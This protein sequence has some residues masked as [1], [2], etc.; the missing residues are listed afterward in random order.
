MEAKHAAELAALEAEQRRYQ[1]REREIEEQLKKMEQ[2]YEQTTQALS[3][4]RE[5]VKY[6]S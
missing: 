5:Q 1:H 2:E 4:Q 3:D 6:V